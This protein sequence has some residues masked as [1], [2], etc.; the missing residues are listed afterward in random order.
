MQ[1]RELVK[2]V[3]HYSGFSDQESEMALRTFVSTLGTRLTP[4]E[5][6]HFASQLPQ[7]LKEDAM[8]L[9]ESERFG[10]DEFIRR[11]CDES[12]VGESEAK[13]QIFASWSAIKDAVSPGEIRQIKSQLPKDL[14]SM[15]H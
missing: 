11:F 15:L 12:G 6:A 1:Y 2:K 10:A 13:K 8:S 4:D 5:R 7:D 9:E 3:Q 14:D